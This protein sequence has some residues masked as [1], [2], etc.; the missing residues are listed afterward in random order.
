MLLNEVVSEAAMGFL[1]LNEKAA[2]ASAAFV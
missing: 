1:H 2:E